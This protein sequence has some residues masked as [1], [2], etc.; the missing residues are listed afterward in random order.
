[1]SDTRTYLKAFQ[2]W[3]VKDFN[4]NYACVYRPKKS[5][6][7]GMN[8]LNRLEPILMNDNGFKS[9]FYVIESDRY[10]GSAHAHLF[11]ESENVFPNDFKTRLI[12]PKREILD[13][14]PIQSIEAIT[15]YVQKEMGQERFVRNHGLIV[16]KQLEDEALMK[17]IHRE[18]SKYKKGVEANDINKQLISSFEHPNKKY[19]DKAIRFMNTFSFNRLVKFPLV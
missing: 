11:I 6:I 10:K 19:H 12:N 13:L 14:R 5:N 16:R 17:L 2:R 1:M 7:N 18:P 9:M 8:A 3:L 4:F 15:R